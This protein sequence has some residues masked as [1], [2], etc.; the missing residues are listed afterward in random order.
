MVVSLVQHELLGGM[1]FHK[2]PRG[3]VCA[4][5]VVLLAARARMAPFLVKDEL[6]R[7]PGVS[8]LNNE[9]RE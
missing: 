1:H 7:R 2:W 9:T 4:I 6:A 5:S 3:G 8:V